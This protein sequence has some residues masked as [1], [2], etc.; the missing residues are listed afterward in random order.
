MSDIDI[1]MR[2]N[3]SGIFDFEIENDQIVM[4]DGFD[5]VIY[6]SLL[7]DRRAAPEQIG[8]PIHRRGW[9]GDLT[10]ERNRKA[11]SFLYLLEQERLT[12]ST[13]NRAVDYVEKALQHLI[14]DEHASDISVNASIVPG[15]GMQLNVSASIYAENGLISDK[16][17]TIW[18]ATGI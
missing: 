18:L 11:G 8:D 16:N 9:A 4:D 10:D 15:R 1:K 5:T 2:R 13:L 3:T 6:N 7:T 12:Q 14:D 17:I